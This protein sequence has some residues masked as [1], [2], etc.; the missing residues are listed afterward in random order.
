MVYKADLLEADGTKSEV[1]VKKV[2][3]GYWMSRN[4]PMAKA[5]CVIL[6]GF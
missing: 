3:S 1:V 5:M 4:K 2:R 6:C